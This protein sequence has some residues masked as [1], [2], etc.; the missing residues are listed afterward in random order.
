VRVAILYLAIGDYTD[1]WTDFYSSCEKN[2]LPDCEKNYFVFTDRPSTISGTNV[3]VSSVDDLGW[4][5]NTMFRFKYFLRHRDTL[6]SHD[7]VF[8]FNANALFCETISMKDVLPPGYTLTGVVHPGY[9]KYRKIFLPYERKH[10]NSTA[11]VGRFEGDCYFQGCLN[12]G[13]SN[14]YMDLVEC[15]NRNINQDLRANIIARAHDES[16]LNRYL[17]EKKVNM[18]PSCYSLPEGWIGD[19]I[20]SMRDKAKYPWYSGVKN[21]SAGSGKA[22]G[23]VKSFVKKIVVE[24][25]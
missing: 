21:A 11:Y 7:A 9:Q 19:P 24:S 17:I 12:G 4:P 13:F 3:H 15:C 16:H 10:R 22:L 2:F 20:I 23:L 6:R 18:L 8:F 25:R 5:L 1:F 14:E